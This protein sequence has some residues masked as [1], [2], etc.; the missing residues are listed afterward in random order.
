MQEGQNL[1]AVLPT[2][3]TKMVPGFYMLFA[4]NEA[5]VPSVARIVSVM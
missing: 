2:D 5:R 1:T 4:F 3:P